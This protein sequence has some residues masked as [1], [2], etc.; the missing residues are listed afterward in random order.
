M[1]VIVFWRKSNSMKKHAHNFLIV[2]PILD[3]SYRSLNKWHWFCN[4]KV[5]FSTWIWTIRESNPRPYTSIRMIVGIE[6]TPMYLN[7]KYQGIEPA[8]THQNMNNLGDRTYDHDINA[9]NRGIEPTT[10]NT[11]DQG[12]EPATT[13]IR[14]YSWVQSYQNVWL[15]SYN[16]WVRSCEL[17]IHESNHIK[18]VWF[19]SYNAWI[20]FMSPITSTYMS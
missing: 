14:T 3:F 13:Y 16:A 20:K 1:N 11:N 4:S 2:M 18:N 19:L 6:P 15:L 9:I 12:I 17:Q 5:P 8:T 7:T 10:L